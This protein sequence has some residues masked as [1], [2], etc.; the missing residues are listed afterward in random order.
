M[1]GMVLLLTLWYGLLVLVPRS[2]GWF[3]RF[4]TGLSCLGRLVFGIRSGLLCLHLLTVLRTLL[5]GPLH[6]VSW[7]SGFPFLGSLHLPAG[8]LDLGVGG[9]SNVELLIIYELWAGERLSLEK[10]QPRYLRPA[11]NF[12]VGCSFWSRH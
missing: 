3:M 10:A 2:V 1:V 9:A 8:G 6:L 11:R 4:G 7:L 5:T 12:S